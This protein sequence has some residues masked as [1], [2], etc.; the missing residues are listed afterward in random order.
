[1]MNS[2]SSNILLEALKDKRVVIVFTDTYS[3]RGKMKSISDEDI[4]LIMKTKELTIRY[5]DIKS[6]E[7]DMDRIGR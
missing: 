6:C 3:V 5:K 4:V 1:M 2:Q 7:F